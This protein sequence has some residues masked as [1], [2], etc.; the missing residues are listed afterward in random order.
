MSENQINIQNDDEIKENVI[1]DN[2]SNNTSNDTTNLLDNNLSNENIPLINYA[3]Q[4]LNIISNKTALCFEGG[5]VL[6]CAHL[7]ALR[8]LNDIGGLKNITHV[9]GTSV[10]SIIAA[11]VGCGAGI[12]Y[13]EEKF[14]NLDLNSFKDGSGCLFNLCRLIKKGSDT[15]KGYGWYKGDQIENFAGQI[16]KELTSNSDITFNEAYQKYGIRLTIVYFSANYNKTRYADYKTAPS[17]KIKKAIRM[18]SAIPVYYSA[19]WK[20]RIGKSKEVFV[21]GG[22]TDNYALHV[23]KEQ[24]CSLNSILGFKLCSIVEFNEYKEDIGE[25]VE[26]IDNGPPSN[27]YNHVINIIGVIHNQALKYHVHKE[28]WMVTVKIDVGS[29]SSTNFGITQDQQ[30]WLYNQGKI[31]LQKHVEDVSQMLEN[32]E[33]F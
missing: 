16:L 15:Q 33:T 7:G 32:N 17:L 31:A 30:M 1:N 3:E 24:G 20:N 8:A 13:M 12:D 19:V 10:G 25:Y 18:S 22:L 27:I 5:G 29:Y 4:A 28:D 9:V 14:F 23:L 6:G 21:D 2:T 26:E 11:A